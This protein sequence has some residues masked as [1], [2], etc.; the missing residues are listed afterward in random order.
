M[1]V[2][3]GC[4]PGNMGRAWLGTSCVLWKFFCMVD[5]GLFVGLVRGQGDCCEQFSCQDCR[6]TGSSDGSVDL[7]FR[8]LCVCSRHED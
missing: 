5:F 8:R 6:G 4:I 1:F 3:F 2:C 7:N